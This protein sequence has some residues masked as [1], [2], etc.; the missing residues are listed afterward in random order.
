MFVFCVNY[1][2]ILKAVK[3]LSECAQDEPAM[4]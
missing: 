3:S 2:I 1:Y 4:I